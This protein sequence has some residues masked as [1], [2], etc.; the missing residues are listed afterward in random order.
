MTSDNGI[1]MFLKPLPTLLLVVCFLQGCN[2]VDSCSGFVGTFH[3]SSSSGSYREMVIRKF[4][5]RY[6]V[7]ST[8]YVQDLFVGTTTK[9]T[10]DASCVDGVLEVGP[11]KVP[12]QLTPSGSLRGEGTE[13]LP[14][15]ATKKQNGTATSKAG[16]SSVG[17]S[18]SARPTSAPQTPPPASLA[19]PNRT[20]PTDPHSKFEAGGYLWQGSLAGTGSVNVRSCGGS[21]CKVIA[22]LYPEAAPDIYAVRKHTSD[23]SPVRVVTRDLNG[24]GRATVEG[25]MKNSILDSRMAGGYNH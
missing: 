12:L 18:A 5:K 8:N 25:Y 1:V 20:L 3:A 7:Q 17:S 2:S 19:Q 6:E 9:D 16:S 4:Q 24:E 14:G 10:V 13:Y 11:F 15:P 21:S 23:W 22:E